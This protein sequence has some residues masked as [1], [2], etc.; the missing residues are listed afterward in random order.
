MPY[1]FS[2]PCHPVI[3]RPKRY[4]DRDP[5]SGFPPTRAILDFASNLLTTNSPETNTQAPWLCR[6]KDEFGRLV[7]PT[8]AGFKE[9]G[10][11]VSRHSVAPRGLHPGRAKMD[12]MRAQHSMAGSIISG[13]TLH[14]KLQSFETLPTFGA[15]IR[16]PSSSSEMLTYFQQSEAV[17]PG[18]LLMKKAHL[19]IRLRMAALIRQR[20][21]D[22]PALMSTFL[23]RSAFSRMPQRGFSC[24]DVTTFRR[25]ICYV[26]GDQ[27]TALAMTHDELIEIYSPFIL[28]PMADGEGRISWR[29]FAEDIMRAAGLSHDNRGYLQQ[30]ETLAQ[31][32]TATDD[33]SGEFDVSLLRRTME[34]LYSHDTDTEEE[35]QTRVLKDV[36]RVTG[37]RSVAVT[38]YGSYESKLV[39]RNQ[40]GTLKQ[41]DFERIGGHGDYRKEQGVSADGSTIKKVN[42]QIGSQ[43]HEYNADGTI[44]VDTG[45]DVNQTLSYNAKMAADA[46]NKAAGQK[47]LAGQGPTKE[48]QEVAARMNA[49]ALRQDAIKMRQNYANAMPNSHQEI[50]NQLRQVDAITAA[51]KLHASLE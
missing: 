43:S 15:S 14:S 9:A 13:G 31:R 10:D 20:T 38:R 4:P 41:G 3:D 36:E 26:F 49:E 5:I 51:R 29:T 33:P 46:T 25:A 47:S 19:P 23:Q 34:A 32:L 24:I 8:G 42:T 48:Q 6:E 39:G 37:A 18:D 40:L 16:L 7:A 50:G 12:R 17:M 11:I 22:V 1:A 2:Q 28:S 45:G 30:E 35:K 44:C 27:W 21:M